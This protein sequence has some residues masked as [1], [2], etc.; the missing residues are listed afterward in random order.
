MDECDSVGLRRVDERRE[1]D[2]SAGEMLALAYQRLRQCCQ[3]KPGMEDSV[4]TGSPARAGDVT[5]SREV[6]A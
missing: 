3:S 1:P 2:R 6:V 5:S 4:Q